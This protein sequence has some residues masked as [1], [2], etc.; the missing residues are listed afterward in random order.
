[1]KTPF[2]TLPQVQDIVKTIP[3]PL[4]SV[5]RNRYPELC[6][7]SQGRLF[8]ESRLSGIFRRQGHAQSADFEDFAGGGLLVPTV[9]P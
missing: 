5:R 7:P 1:M 3:H 6:P 4:L 8:L 2:V 9:L